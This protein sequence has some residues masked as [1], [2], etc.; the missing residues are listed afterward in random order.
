MQTTPGSVV[1]EHV[2]LTGPIRGTVTLEDGTTYDVSPFAVEAPLEHHDEIAHLIGLRYAAEGHPDHDADTPFVY[3]TPDGLRLQA[4]DGSMEMAYSATFA[5]QA[6]DSGTGGTTNVLAFVSCHTGA[7]GG[8]G[9]NEYAGVTRLA[10]SWNA[11]SSRAKTNSSALTFTTS[12]ASAVTNF[13]SFSAVTA[14]TYGIDMPLSSSVTAVTITV[15]AGALSLS[16]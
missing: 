12:G 9:A 6:L 5:N 10:C 13:G 11:A 7:P 8:T 2:V 1:G 15:A 14:G 16:A 4:G 3:T